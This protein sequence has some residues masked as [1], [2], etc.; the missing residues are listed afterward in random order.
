M[1][2]KDDPPNTHISQ[3]S[4]NCKKKAHADQGFQ[5]LQCLRQLVWK[6]LETLLSLLWKFFKSLYIVFDPQSDLKALSGGT[7]KEPYIKD[8]KFSLNFF[9]T[10]YLNSIPTSR[11]IYPCEDRWLLSRNTSSFAKGTKC[12]AKLANCLTFLLLFFMMKYLFV[13]KFDTIGMFGYFP[14]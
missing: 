8:K 10:S 12:D 2:R 3:Y 6:R 9:L 1:Q 13:L 7:L 4:V 5:L 11:Y 14:L